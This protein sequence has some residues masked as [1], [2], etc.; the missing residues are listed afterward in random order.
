[1][2]MEISDTEKEVSRMCNLGEALYE[3]ALNEGIEQG[4][5]QGIEKG[6]EQSLSEM[7]KKKLAK[8]KSISTIADEIEESEEVVNDIIVKYQL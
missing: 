2:I 3:K 7:I 8:G 5:E 1:M 6:I 4:I